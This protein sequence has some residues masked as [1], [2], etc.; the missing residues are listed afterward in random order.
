MLKD[1]YVD[2]WYVVSLVVV[3]ELPRIEKL[4]TA[5]G[6]IEAFKTRFGI[7]FHVLLWNSDDSPLTGVVY[8]CHWPYVFSGN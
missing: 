7:V 5:V 3:W 6:I 1:A 4:N 8:R 2:G